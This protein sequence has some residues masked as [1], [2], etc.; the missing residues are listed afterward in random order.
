MRN[1]WFVVWTV[2][3]A[4]AVAG[5]A[6]APETADDAHAPAFRVAAPLPGAAIALVLSGGSARGFAH[7]GVIAALEAHGLRPDLIVGSSTGSIVGALYASGLRAADL[8]A[9]IARLDASAFLDVAVPG[10][11]FFPSPLGIVRGDGLMR[12]I[13]REARHRRI[14][15]FPMRFAAVATDLAS[16]TPQIFNAGDAA[17]AV[18]ASSAVPGL[19]TPQRI[20]GRL[21]GDGQV[22]S[23]LPVSAARELGA[24]IVIAVDVIYPP[25]D[26]SLTS[27]PRL[28]SQGF[29]ITV[30]R[31]KEWEAAA[32]DIVLAPELGHTSG[33]WLFEERERLVAAGEAAT[34][35]ALD[36]LRPL[37]PGG[38]PR[39]P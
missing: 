7:V 4:T 8:K 2:A 19:I 6:T 18:G 23:P 32:A 21:Y 12:Y 35:R 3:L 1:S 20:R 16:G 29:L 9:A 10:V 11:L 36:R 38:G 14:E 24:R 25:E 31:L 5:C 34:L 22:S 13:E 37:F 15:D 33:Q 26:S 28:F 30:H 17:R 27:I 39:P